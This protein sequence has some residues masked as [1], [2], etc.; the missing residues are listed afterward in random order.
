MQL[1]LQCEVEV[2]TP[3]DTRLEYVGCFDE[4]SPFYMCQ[5]SIDLDVLSLLSSTGEEPT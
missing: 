1:G 3:G 5:D 4:L 2:N